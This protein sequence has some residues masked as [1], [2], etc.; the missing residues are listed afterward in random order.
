MLTDLVASITIAI[1]VNAS[2]A[3]VDPY[4]PSTGVVKGRD[5]S[6]ESPTATPSSE[7]RRR[8]R[9]G[10]G[11][12]R[13]LRSTVVVVQPNTPSPRT[14]RPS[15]EVPAKVGLILSY[16]YANLSWVFDF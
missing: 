7:I 16:F 8:A 12:P 9:L 11:R 3:E 10:L 15:W 2:R 6:F 5:I 14:F 13:N 4:V 1:D